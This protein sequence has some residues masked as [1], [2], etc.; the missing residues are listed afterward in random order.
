MVALRAGGDSADRRDCELAFQKDVLL[1]RLRERFAGWELPARFAALFGSAASGRMH[2]DSDIDI[3]V[4]RPDG[5]DDERWW[6]QLAELE[7]AVTSWTGNDTRIMELSDSE[8][9]AAVASNERVLVD[10]ADTGIPLFGPVRYMATV[11]QRSA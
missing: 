8:I 10:I 5:L 11:R 7:H 2:P 9:V 6:D 3:F 4:V 1:T